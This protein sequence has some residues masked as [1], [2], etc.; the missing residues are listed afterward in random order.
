MTVT[1]WPIFT[2]LRGNIVMREDE[3]QSTPIGEPLR[4][5]DTLQPDV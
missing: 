3:L 1:G 4:F 2:I 5:Q